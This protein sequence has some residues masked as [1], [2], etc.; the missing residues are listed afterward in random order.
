VQRSEKGLVQ[1]QLPPG[2]H[3]VEVYFH[4]PRKPLWLGLGIT[5]L[6]LALLSVATLRSRGLRPLVEK[7]TLSSASEALMP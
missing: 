4:R 1:L 7:T 6:S 5:L 2:D 3:R